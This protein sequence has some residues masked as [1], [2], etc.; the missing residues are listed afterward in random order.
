MGN[1]E[2]NL[3]TNSEGKGVWETSNNGFYDKER[4][5]TQSNWLEK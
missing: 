5:T 3:V 4:L 2:M 1:R